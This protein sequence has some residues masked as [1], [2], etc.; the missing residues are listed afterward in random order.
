VTRPSTPPLATRREVLAAYR[1]LRAQIRRVLEAAP[2]TCTKVEI[3]R[4]AGLLGLDLA[5]PDAA[6]EAAMEMLADLSLFDPDASGR[7]AIDRFAAARGARGP[8][9]EDRALAKRIAQTARFSVF[10]IAARH[11]AAGVWLEDMLDDGRRIWLM[12]EALE[13]Q[14][15]GLSH[16]AMRVFDAGPFHCG[17]G[18]VAALDTAV[19]AACMLEQQTTGEPP[20]GPRFAAALYAAM[21]GTTPPERAAR[22]R[23]GASRRRPPTGGG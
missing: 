5:D 2:L 4:A 19:A 9:P 12:D 7:R 11:K 1:P 10:F 16:L 15:S 20:F 3:T 23:A 14:R 8:A 18:I 22:P 17:F 6:T 13:A 21:L